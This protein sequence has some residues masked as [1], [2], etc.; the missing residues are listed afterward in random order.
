MDTKCVIKVASWTKFMQYDYKYLFTFIA[1][2]FIILVSYV[3]QQLFINYYL[4]FI[5]SEI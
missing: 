3:L 1:C 5:E 4:T 2:I